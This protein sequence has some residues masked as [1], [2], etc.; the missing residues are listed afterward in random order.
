[1]NSEGGV[2]DAV[3]VVIVVIARVLWRTLLLLLL[4]L[5]LLMLFP[6]EPWRTVHEANA[7]TT[8]IVSLGRPPVVHL[9]T[10]GGDDDDD[11]GD[12]DDDDKNLVINVFL[13]PL[14]QC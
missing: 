10:A 14:G 5:L 3:V 4:L 7:G 1:M 9:D 6:R 2:D 8:T 13:Y 12:G 11:D